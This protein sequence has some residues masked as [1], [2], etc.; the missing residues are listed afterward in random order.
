MARGRTAEQKRV[1]TSLPLAYSLVFPRANYRILDSGDGAGKGILFYAFYTEKTLN[2]SFIAVGRLGG[3]G[4]CLCLMIRQALAAVIVLLLMFT[5]KEQQSIVFR[6]RGKGEW[7]GTIHT[8]AFC[9]PT[10]GDHSVQTSLKSFWGQ[11]GGHGKHFR[12]AV[13]MM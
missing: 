8:E 5:G 9:H 10:A 13:K 6:G 12:P 1:C 11:G 3:W 7:C 4:Y 2:G